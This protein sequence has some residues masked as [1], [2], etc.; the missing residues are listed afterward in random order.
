MN[1]ATTIVLWVLRIT[2]TIQIVLGLL[3]WT[4]NVFALLPVH[5]LSGFILVLALW[6]LA[7]LAGLAG[8]SRGAVALALVWGLVV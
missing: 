7:I 8:A 5:I 6:T 2:G 3:F 4:N 1:M